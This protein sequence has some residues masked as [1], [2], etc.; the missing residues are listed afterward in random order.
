MH[1]TT[2]PR[3]VHYNI[4]F[5]TVSMEGFCSARTVIELNK[6]VNTAKKHTYNIASI[7]KTS[8]CNFKIH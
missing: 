6:K 2:L 3:T 4:L 1:L 8:E 5:S 7:F